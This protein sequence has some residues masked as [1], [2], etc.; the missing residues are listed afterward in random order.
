MALTADRNTLFKDGEVI[1]VPVASNVKIFAGAIVAANAT[2]FATKGAAATTLTYL[3]R[4]DEFVDNTGGAD[5]AKTIMV[6]RK[7]AFKWKNST[8][9]VVQADLGKVCYIE[10]DQTVCHTA[11]GKSVAGT[12][13]G[14]ETDGVWVDV[15]G[16]QGVQG[17]QGIQ[18]EP[19][20][21]G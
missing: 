6:R 14:V 3:G 2:G 5:G 13:V 11:S 21:P 15:I 16:S 7:K 10:D 19:G 1:T 8:D 4:A 12:V 20:T 17:I 18:G 9:A